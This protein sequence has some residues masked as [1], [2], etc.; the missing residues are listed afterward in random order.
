MSNLMTDLD[1]HFVSS[2]KQQSTSN[3]IVEQVIRYNLVWVRLRLINRKAIYEKRKLTQTSINSY[4][5]IQDLFCYY[6]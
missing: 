1:F 2:L 3:E 4:K 6:I 5:L